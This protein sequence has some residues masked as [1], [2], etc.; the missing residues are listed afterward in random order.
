MITGVGNRRIKTLMQMNQKSKV[1]REEKA[2][3]TEGVKMFLEAPLEQIREVY[4]SESFS[5]KGLMENTEGTLEKKL[6]STGYEIVADEVFK[7]ISDTVTPQGILC[8]IKARHYH[9]EEILEGE[10]PLVMLLEDIQ[11]PGNLGTIIRTGEGAGVTGIIMSR[12]TVDIYNPKTIRATMGSVFRVPCMYAEDFPAAVR[13]VQ[14]NHIRVYAAHLKGKEYYD[15]CFYTQG[16]AFLIG[17]EGN[18]LKETTAALAD[19]YLKIPMEG[20]VESLNA[21]VAASVL[22]Y[23]AYR[24]RRKCR[25]KS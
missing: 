23:E 9:T 3:L 11:D 14:R 15:E 12:N 2:F 13:E 16:T 24:Q 6:K 20:K 25:K 21:S 1:R 7:K 18:G 19:G 10:N 8:V 17:N 4:I 22:M 5:M